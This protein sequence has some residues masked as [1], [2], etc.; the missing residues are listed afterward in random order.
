MPRKKK[1]LIFRPK[2]KWKERK[3]MDESA[4]QLQIH[5]HSGVSSEGLTNELDSEISSNRSA[6]VNV[7]D[8]AATQMQTLPV[9]HDHAYCR[10]DALSI[11]P[12]FAPVDHDHAY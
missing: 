12:N 1:A 3:K 6:L 5:T 9:D 4:N 7:H 2:S 10:L 8:S 11:P